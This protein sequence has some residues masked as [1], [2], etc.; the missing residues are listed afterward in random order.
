MGV[1]SCLSS[2]AG[3]AVLPRQTTK[4]HSTLALPKGLLFGGLTIFGKSVGKF[5]PKDATIKTMEIWAVSN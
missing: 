5:S 3:T 1:P 4:T 2:G